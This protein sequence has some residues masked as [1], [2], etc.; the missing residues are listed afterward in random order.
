MAGS[1]S[2]ISMLTL[3]INSLNGPLK[4]QSGKRLSLSGK[5]A[6]FK[7]PISMLDRS[8]QSR[9]PF[10]SSTKLCNLKLCF[11]PSEIL[12]C[13]SFQFPF[14]LYYFLMRFLLVSSCYSY[15]TCIS[16]LI[17]G[18]P[19]LS[20]FGLMEKNLIYHLISSIC[21]LLWL[22]LLFLGVALG[23]TTCILIY[24]SLL[25]VN[26]V[27]PDF[28]LHGYFLLS[29][30]PFK[31]VTTLQR[32]NIIHSYSFYRLCY[33]IFFFTYFKPHLL[34]NVGLFCLVLL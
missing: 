28:T 14:I 6:V 12:F 13:F 26:V 3:H 25:R 7:R 33:Y 20:S 1:K 8:Q 27:R 34:Y 24:Q 29:A 15:F 21:F 4:R 11:L 19:F 32:Y 16:S 5:F 23:L 22:F 30:F 9:F 10:N 17:L 18:C 2:H 31:N